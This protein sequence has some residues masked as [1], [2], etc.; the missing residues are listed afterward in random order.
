MRI[1]ALLVVE[2]KDVLICPLSDVF[3]GSLMGGNLKGE[4]ILRPIEVVSTSELFS[5]DL[6]AEVKRKHSTVD[7]FKW[8]KGESVNGNLYSYVLINGTNGK[9]V[10]IFFA[11]K[12]ASGDGYFIITDQ[13]KRVAANSISDT[14]LKSLVENA[15]IVPKC[16]GEESMVVVGIFNVFPH[17][18]AELP[19]RS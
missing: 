13:R 3:A 19:Q 6:G 14:T 12:K 17:K 8:L 11:L 1:N 7:C 18:I 4:V 5:A 16:A 10:D 15:S 2:G 9:G